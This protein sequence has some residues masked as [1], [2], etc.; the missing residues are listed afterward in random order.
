MSDCRRSP[1]P[2][3]G[4]AGE[5]FASTWTFAKQILPLLFFGVLVAGFLLGR[6][7]HEGFIPSKYVQMLV[8]D[9]PDTLFAI[10]GWG[11]GGFESF[12]RA[13]WPFWTNFFASRSSGRSCTSPR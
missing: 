2:T 6:V 3:K 12:V 1:A 10:T 9:S 4:E 8:G 7:D 5:W 13:I 11:G